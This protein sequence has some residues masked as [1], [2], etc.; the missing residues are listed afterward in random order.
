MDGLINRL[1]SALLFQQRLLRLVPQKASIADLPG[2]HALES[3]LSRCVCMQEV[4]TYW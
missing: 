2:V 3:T 1:E 4:L